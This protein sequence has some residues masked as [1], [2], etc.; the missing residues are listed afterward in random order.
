[1]SVQNECT[2]WVYCI[3]G[4]SDSTYAYEDWVLDNI[5]NTGQGLYDMLTQFWFILGKLVC[6]ENQVKVKCA[7]QASIL[8]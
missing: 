1:M 8:D 6:T 3:L 7:K 5:V 4:Q 2:E